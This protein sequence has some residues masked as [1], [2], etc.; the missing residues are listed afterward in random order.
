[1]QFQNM[2]TYFITYYTVPNCT[3]RHNYTVL[4]K[5]LS[6]LY[7][8]YIRIGF[9]LTRIIFSPQYSEMLLKTSILYTLSYFF[10]KMEVNFLCKNLV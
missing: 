10:E 5:V 4:L 9:H 3:A 8:T 2:Q 7:I 1:M 6:P